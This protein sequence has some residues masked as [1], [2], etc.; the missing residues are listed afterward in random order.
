MIKDE[1]TTIKKEGFVPKKRA[2]F[3]AS[4]NCMLPL[5]GMLI[6][7][8]AGFRTLVQTRNLYAFYMFSHLLVFVSSPESDTQATAYLLNFRLLPGDGSGYP[9]IDCTPI[10]SRNKAEPLAGCFVPA[11]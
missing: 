8:A 5:D 10:A 2:I 1:W 6:S 7:G 4:P 11:P 9:Y 3:D